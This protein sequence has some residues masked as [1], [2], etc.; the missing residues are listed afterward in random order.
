M[1][2][3]KGTT[4]GFSYNYNYIDTTAIMI[5]IIIIILTKKIIINPKTVCVIGERQG[6]GEVKR[7]LVLAGLGDS[8]WAE[9]PRDCYHLEKISYNA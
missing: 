8:W 6:I 3:T 1:Y 7:R 5:I 4:F 9:L 2:G